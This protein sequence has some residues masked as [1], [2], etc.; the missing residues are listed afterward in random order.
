MKVFFETNK[1]KSLKIN[2]LTR[3]QDNEAP[4]RFATDI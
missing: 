2:N 4:V 3:K 1:F